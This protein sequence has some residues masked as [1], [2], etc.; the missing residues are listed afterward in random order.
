MAGKALN[1]KV[2]SP[3]K[4]HHG[5]TGKYHA[6]CHYSYNLPLAVTIPEVGSDYGMAYLDVDKKSI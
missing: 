5:L 6:I 4:L 2:Y 3:L 1:I